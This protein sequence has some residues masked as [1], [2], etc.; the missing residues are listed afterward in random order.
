VEGVGRGNGRKLE[1]FDGE[2]KRLKREMDDF[3]GT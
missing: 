1:R 3:E 2:M